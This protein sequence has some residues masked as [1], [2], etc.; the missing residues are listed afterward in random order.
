PKDDAEPSEWHLR[1]DTLL[2]ALERCRDKWGDL[3]GEIEQLSAAS[4][5]ELSATA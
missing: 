2:P 1:L 4:P 5:S 3:P